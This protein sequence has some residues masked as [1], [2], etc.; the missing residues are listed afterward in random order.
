MAAIRHRSKSD[1]DN[2]DGDDNDNKDDDDGIML[3]DP[4]SEL[5]TTNKSS[6]YK[7]IKRLSAI[8]LLS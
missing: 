5:S 2:N 6:L 4:A 7:G 8:S 1:H 3:T